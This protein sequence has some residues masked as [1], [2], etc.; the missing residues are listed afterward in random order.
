MYTVPQNALVNQGTIVWVESI[1]SPDGATHGL[2]GPS[3]AVGITHTMDASGFES[4]S[5]SPGSIMDSAGN[6]YVNSTTAGQVFIPA[7][8]TDPNGNQINISPSLITDTLGRQISVAGGPDSGWGWI[9]PWGY[10]SANLYSQ[11]SGQTSAP[12]SVTA[13]TG[14]PSGSV[15]ARAWTVPAY[16][17]GSS[18]TATYTFC[19]GQY[20]ISSSFG[21]SWIT[22]ESTTN[23]FI[24]AVLLP[25]GTEWTFSYDAY[26]DLAKVT[27]PTGGY[28][29]YGWAIGTACAS[30]G[31]YLTFPPDS[32]HSRV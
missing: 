10:G 19:Y 29:A 21:V 9:S 32:A 15:S 23:R 13:T 30:G 3:R 22:D 31:L 24:N 16:N 20:T 1:A 26:G 2:D 25:N 4:N 12:G 5:A 17:N 11:N 6:V 8:W 18:S 14:C 28:V 7:T 27:L